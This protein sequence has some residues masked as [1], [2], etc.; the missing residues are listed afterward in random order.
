MTREQQVK[1]RIEPMA[2]KSHSPQ[3]LELTGGAVR[4]IIEGLIFASP[5]PVTEENLISL[6]GSENRSAIQSALQ[7]L[8][9]EYSQEERGIHIEQVAGGYRFSTKSSVGKWI[10]EFALISNKAKLSPASIET[11]SIIAYKQPI[12]LPEIQFIRGVNPA[13]AIKTL[14]EKKLI[15]ITG[16]KRTVG[17]PFT[18]GTTKQFLIHFGLDSLYDLPSIEQFNS[19]LNSS[20]EIEGLGLPEVEEKQNVSEEE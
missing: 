6:L 13:G 16:R 17:K 18:Y 2:R 19:M 12:T 5:E 14:L 7:E 1:S 9:E 15:R 4:S 11:L 20:A 8:V 10:K 3:N